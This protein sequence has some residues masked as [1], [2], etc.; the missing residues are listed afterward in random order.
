[1]AYGD[2][3]RRVPLLTAHPSTS[4]HRDGFVCRTVPDAASGSQEAFPFQAGGSI[5][6][7]PA[8]GRDQTIIVG[9]DDGSVYW[10][11]IQNTSAGSQLVP[12]FSFKTSA[13]VSSSP[14]LTSIQGFGVVYFGS[15]DS[16]IY[17]IGGGG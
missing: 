11:Q 9:S 14:A 17:S 8:I 10:L 4:L 7:S 3:S 15:L 16:K 2:C 5:R 13:G 1:M 6:S 12:L